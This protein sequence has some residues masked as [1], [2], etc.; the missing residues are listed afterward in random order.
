MDALAEPMELSSDIYAR[1]NSL[2]EEANRLIKNNPDLHDL[3]EQ[4]VKEFRA[5]HGDKVGHYPDGTPEEENIDMRVNGLFDLFI[6]ETPIDAMQFDTP[7]GA[8]EKLIQ[9]FIA[10]ARNYPAAKAA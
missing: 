8:V 7:D 10:R 4:M 1:G 2:V 9:D 6:G 3:K 5:A